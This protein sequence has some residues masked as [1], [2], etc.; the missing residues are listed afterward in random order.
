ML[1]AEIILNALK[2]QNVDTIFGYPGGVTLPLYDQIYQ[3]NW[4]RHIVCRHEQGSMHA[5]EGYA[6]STGKTGVVLV[7]S[8]P[9]ATNTVTGLTDAMM[10]SIPLVC[11]T[12][13]VPTQIIGN[14]A[15]QE[16]DTTGITRSCTKHNYLVRDVEDL[17]RTLHEAF[18]VAS[19]GRPG[20][21]VVD[22]PKD[23][24]IANGPYIGPGKVRHKTYKPTVK[25]D[26]DKIREAVE[27]MKS[28]KRPIFYCGGGVVNSGP[29]ASDLLRQLVSLSG[30]PCTLTLMALGAFP[31]SDSQFLGMLGM[32]GTYEANM[33]MHDCDVMICIGAR[34]D[35][36]ITGS[37]EDFSPNSRK[38]HI[39]IDPSSI[40]K[41]VMVDVGIVGDVANVLEDMIDVWK[42]TTLKNDDKALKRW[43][44]EI[45]GWR[46]KKCLSYRANGKLAKPQYVLEELQKKIDGRDVFICT[47]VGQHQMW[48]SQ[49]LKFDR[50]KRFMTSGGLGTMGYGLPA[51][52]GVQLAHPD[53]LVVVITSECSIQMNSQELCTLNQYGLPVKVLI[54]NN[55]AMGMVR[56]WQ[57]L[58]YDKRY[59][60]SMMETQPDFMKL[61]DAYGARGLRVDQADQVI[62]VLEEMIAH[63][64]AVVADVRIDPKENVFPMIASGSPHNKMIFAPEDE[65]E[66]TG[67]DVMLA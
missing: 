10:D 53:A 55:G 49:Y 7:T 34:F 11:L 31:A 67:E 20:P 38:I 13:Q 64:G 43:W 16:A 23:V 26:I 62:G 22:L 18:F 37:L 56:Q 52:I 24:I 40:N 1:G 36:R 17:A 63:D 25:G 65:P 39:D 35:D 61:A 42:S 4:L 33:A 32:H 14:D 30:F 57:E 46:S 50:P 51:A 2:D 48:A 59:S 27:L 12:G 28:A 6:R 3:Q 58:F 15:F 21:V 60:Q 47:D 44:N 54:L 41:N 45:D 5:A 19:S 9:G 8:G 66:G 29:A